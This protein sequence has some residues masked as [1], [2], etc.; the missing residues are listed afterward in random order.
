MQGVL[1]TPAEL[2]CEYMKDPIGIDQINPRFSW[3]LQS[4]IRGKAQGAYQ[5]LVSLDEQSL[6]RD[7]GDRWDSG[8]TGSNESVNIAYDGAS[9][10]SGERCFW[11]VRIWDE[12]NEQ[13]PWSDTAVF[14][15][16]LLN[17]K[18]WRG[19]WIAAGDV[20]TSA[21]LVRKNFG[22]DGKVARARAS[23]PRVPTLV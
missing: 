13:G 19:R 20:T 21:P 22:V 16:G 5:I 11:K 9:L 15:M 6:E 14:E 1:M 4:S 7:E 18:D 2:R 8:K 10:H 12:N 3:S 23:R 17:K